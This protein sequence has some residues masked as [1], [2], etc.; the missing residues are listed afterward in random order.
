MTH[1]FPRSS[2]KQI[3]GLKD[4]EKMVTTINYV[5][6][7]WKFT[8]VI[9]SVTRENGVLNINRHVTCSYNGV[10]QISKNIKCKFH[11]NQMQKTC[12]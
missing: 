1:E 7:T 10:N 9:S 2:I 3:V 8:K 11:V 4:L 6:N 12:S 5:Q